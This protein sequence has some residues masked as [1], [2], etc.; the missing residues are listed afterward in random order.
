MKKRYEILQSL[1]VYGPMYIPISS[2]G[3]PF[4]SEGF[5]VKFWKSN[6]ETWVANFAEGWTQYSEVFDFP[7]QHIIIVF[8]YGQGYIMNPDEERPLSTFGLTINEVIQTEDGSLV[9]ANG[10]SIFVLDNRNGE[11]WETQRISWDGMKELKLMG[12][13]L[14]GQAYTPMNSNEPWVSFEVN[15]DTKEVKGGSFFF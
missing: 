8:A 15:L 13:I 12:S 14:H 1:P 11:A 10:I 9:C 7:E 5:V 4:Y 6:G 3:E 2:D